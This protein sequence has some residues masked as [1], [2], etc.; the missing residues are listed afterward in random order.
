MRVE[1]RIVTGDR[2]ADTVNQVGKGSDGAH[3]WIAGAVLGPGVHTDAILLVFSGKC[4]VLGSVKVGAV[5][6]NVG[7]LRY[8]TLTV[9]TKKA[10]P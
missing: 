9:E 8:D 3:D 6:L 7:R 4:D 1:G 5:W 10:L 2:E